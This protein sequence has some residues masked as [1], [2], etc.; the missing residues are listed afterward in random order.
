MATVKKVIDARGLSCPEPAI[1][2]EQ[3]LDNLDKMGGGELEVMVDSAASRENVDR[4]YPQRH[5]SAQFSHIRRGSSG[6]S[7]CRH[8]CGAQCGNAAVA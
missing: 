3:A 6:G 7:G 4:F 8:G 5:G 1:L 2:A